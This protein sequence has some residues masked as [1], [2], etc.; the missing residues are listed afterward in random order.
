M[1]VFLSYNSKNRD[2]VLKIQTFL[3]KRGF[4]TF[5]DVQDIESGDKWLTTIEDSLN[6]SKAAVIFIGD[7]GVGP[8]QKKE[9]LDVLDKNLADNEYKILP[10]LLPKQNDVAIY[11]LPW[12]LKDIQH[13]SF[14]SDTDHYALDVLEQKLKE[15]VKYSN[16]VIEKN[17]YKGLNSFEVE[18]AEYFFGRNSNLNEIF[19][20]KLPLQKGI[21]GHNFLAVVADSGVGKSSFV[22]AGIIGSLLK[23]KFENSSSWKYCIIKPG[24]DP[25][26][27]LSSEL[28]IMQFIDNTRQFEEDCLKYD[29][30]LL[31]MVRDQ[32]ETLV[33]LVDQF[34]EVITQCKDENIRKVFIDV[35]CRLIETEK[36]I[37]LLTLRSDYYSQFAQFDNF[38][39]LLEKNNYT[40]GDINKSVNDFQHLLREIIVT[41]AKINGVK[42]EN[43]LVDKLINECKSISGALP[44]LQFVLYKIWNSTTIK[45]KIITSTEY[46]VLSK[47]IGISG[48]IK[49]HTEE[50][51]NELTNFGNDKES[52]QLIR[53][54][55]I[56]NL[57]ELTKSQ[58]DVRRTAKKEDL[59]AIE[60]FDKEDVERMLKNL[61][62]KRIITIDKDE[63]VE[64]VHEVII[65]EWEQLKK[66]IN[67]SREDI[68]YKDNLDKTI[69]AFA[70]GEDELYHGRKLKKLNEW[71]KHNDFLVTDKIK[72]FAHKSNNKKRIVFYS[73]IGASLVLLTAGFFLYKSFQSTSLLN[74]IKN[75]TELNENFEAVGGNLDSIQ[76]LVLDKENHDFIYKN[77]NKFTHLD[78]L[79]VYNTLEEI[80]YNEFKNVAIK[81]LKVSGYS[82]LSILKNF[83]NA[84]SLTSLVISDNIDL[85]NIADIENVNFITHLTIS[86]NNLSSLKGIESLTKLTH[87]IISDNKNLT[88]LQEIGKIKTLTSL[89]I[90][91]YDNLKTLKGLENLQSLTSLYISDNEDLINLTGI[92]NLKN[93]NQLTV[94][95]NDNLITLK[96]IEKIQAIAD[97]KIINN[98]KL[99]NL[100]G[101]EKLNPITSLV[102]SGNKTLTSLDEIGSL[103]TLENLEISNNVK[104]TN[105]SGL[106]NFTRLKSLKLLDNEN[107]TSINGIENLKLITSLAIS[108]NPKL[109]N[110]N[111]IES[112][113]ILESLLISGDFDINQLT[114]N[115]NLKSIA[116]L[117]IS[118]TKIQDLEAISS[119]QSLTSLTIS[120]NNNLLSLKGIEKLARLDNL[121]ISN[122]PQLSSIEEIENL[123]AVASLTI[124]KNDNLRSLRGIE[125]IKSITVLKVFDMKSLTNFNRIKKLSKLK[126]LTLYNIPTVD[127]K[128]TNDVLY[129]LKGLKKLVLNYTFKTEYEIL[130]Q[131]NPGIKIIR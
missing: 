76:T 35:I 12:F 72:T 28:K 42:I 99:E 110:L 9:I 61:S 80:D 94:L 32:K 93:I 5:F 107:L 51:Y 62:N 49:E 55:F 124:S 52:E 20:D 92:E 59:F 82:D 81:C 119:L 112:I 71:I 4:E 78:T 79:R 17:P 125:T 123:K 100:S 30:A 25:L 106:K 101:I 3:E 113:N 85:K 39:R 40:L 45:D 86:N 13:I 102:V 127:N 68:V 27:S 2:F 33:L 29:D 60:R 14:T 7:E 97:L 70:K 122:N 56:P 116:S 87:L 44:I 111:G 131:Q 75:D 8:W 47:S 89:R 129:K 95:R 65:R 38:K 115:T 88:S 105:L 22:K 50:S 63:S 73:Q 57:V 130:S 103:T 19:Y 98:Y 21:I 74:S 109:Q 11:S 64:I 16:V 54:I 114:K 31:R 23:G 15:N 18:D 66:W 83:K 1:S 84:K 46:D 36:A 24:T 128:T 69:D 91:D 37:V 26:T 121:E 48:I 34:E 126:E 96:A 41:P 67:E 58:T 117:T 77:L 10:V 120:N 43:A 6:K 90:S 53:R 108:N 104:L 118:N